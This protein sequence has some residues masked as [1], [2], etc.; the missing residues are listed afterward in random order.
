[1]PQG[2]Y[3]SKALFERLILGGAYI[4]RGL[5][6]EGYLHYKIDWTSLWFKGNLCAIVLFLF[7]FILY[8]K[9]ISNH[10]PR[11]YIQ[12]GILTNGFLCNEFEGYIFGGAYMRRGLFWNVIVQQNYDI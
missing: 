9:A 2:L 4:R 11:A 1:M 6:M 7:C 3:F 8:L 5:Y 12:M 10:K